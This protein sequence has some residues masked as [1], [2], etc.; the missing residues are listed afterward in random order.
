MKGLNMYS[1]IHQLKNEGL[2]RSQISRHLSINYKTVCKYWNMT[3]AKYHTYQQFQT[4]RPKKLDKY[5]DDIL[6]ML[7]KYND[8]TNAQILD[9]LGDK[10]PDEQDVINYST[11]R[12]YIRCLRSEH[13][14]PKGERVRHYQAIV[15]CKC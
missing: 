9:L 13:N 3:L 7:H 14:I 6:F 10:Y 11:L 1:K 12:K 2:K 15:D 5:K 8:Y 4:K